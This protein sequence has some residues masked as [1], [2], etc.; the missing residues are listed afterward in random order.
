MPFDFRKLYMVRNPEWNATLRACLALGVRRGK[1]RSAPGGP[2]R[3]VV[4][5]RRPGITEGD[6]ARN[7]FGEI[8]SDDEG[9]GVIVVRDDKKAAD[10]RKPVTWE[11]TPLTVERWKE[12]GEAGLIYDYEGLLP[13]M[14]S[15]LHLYEYYND[16]SRA[17]WWTEDVPDLV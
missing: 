5:Y 2:L 3:P 15:T 8:V 1:A 9:T 7:I 13:Y 6:M 4:Q 16:M 11:L 17:E 10:S 14:K 12:M